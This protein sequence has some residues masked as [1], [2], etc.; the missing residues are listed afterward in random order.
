MDEITSI[1]PICDAEAIMY[2]LERV[3]IL[4]RYYVCTDVECGLAGPLRLSAQGALDAFEGLEWHVVSCHECS[5]VIPRNGAQL[6][7]DGT[8][9]CEDHEL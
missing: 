1:C 4:Y 7:G 2:E 5:R 3:G 6:L 8:Y 9:R